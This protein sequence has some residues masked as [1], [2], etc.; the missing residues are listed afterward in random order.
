MGQVPI[1]T[2][3]SIT[4]SRFRQSEEK[5][6]NR[7]RFLKLNFVFQTEIKEEEVKKDPTAVTG[8]E[9]QRGQHGG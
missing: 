8:L 4:Q 9:D 1:Q 7:F 5:Q 3:G 6:S 2:I